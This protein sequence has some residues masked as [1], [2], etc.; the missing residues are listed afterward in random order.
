MKFD[1]IVL[2]ILS[3]LEFDKR[4]ICCKKN[5]RNRKRCVASRNVLVP[6]VLGETQSPFSSAVVL[7]K[8]G[9]AVKML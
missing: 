1:I 8:W 5:N 7:A 3:P 4:I 9:N 6:F 2:S